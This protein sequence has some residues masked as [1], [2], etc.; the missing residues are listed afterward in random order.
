M[1]WWHR[2]RHQDQLERKLDA[3]LRFHVEQETTRLQAAGLSTEEAHRRAMA[4]FGGIEPIK[5]A[6]R[7]VR[8]T[9]WLEDLSQDLRYAARAMRRHPAFAVA[10]VLSLGIGIG[11][12]TAIF[13]V[14]H[15][16]LIRLLPVASPNELSYVTRT[17]PA[18]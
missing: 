7:D 11:A 13:G 14:V 8:G 3:E 2:W 12:N 1:G 18:V 16:L 15:A 6:A 5:E 17:G 9:R 4:S 10:A